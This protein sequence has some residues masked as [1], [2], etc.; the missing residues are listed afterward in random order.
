MHTSGTAP[1]LI[2]F[3][4][5]E[6]IF[7]INEKQAI[8][9]TGDKIVKKTKTITPSPIEFLIS[10][11]PAIIMSK[12]SLKNP[13]TIGIEFEIAYFAAF[14]EIPSNVALVIPCMVKKIENTVVEIPKIHLIVEVNTSINLF[15]LYVCDK[16]DRKL[17]IIIVAIN[18]TIIV[19]TTLIIPFDKNATAG[20]YTLAD[21]LPPA[22][23]IKDIIMGD[24]IAP[25]FDRF[26]IVFLQ[27]I[28]IFLIS[29]ERSKIILKLH[30]NK[31]ILC[32]PSDE[33]FDLKLFIIQQNNA[34]HIIDKKIGIKLD[35]FENKILPIYSNKFP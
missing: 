22:A 16:D 5:A 23:I 7:N 35:R 31:I 33:K 3:I 34:M 9:N 29:S 25:K 24:I 6:E 26:C 27:F 2:K 8:Y 30:I 13:P 11:L 19:D 15:S 17:N 10:I 4:I 21:T 14:I 28:K 32:I 12:P 20:L 1:S 18:G